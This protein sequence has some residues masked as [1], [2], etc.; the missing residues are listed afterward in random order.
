MIDARYHSGVLE[1]RLPK[2]EEA[3]AK[4]IPVSAA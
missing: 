2:S 1:L 4:R 3:Q